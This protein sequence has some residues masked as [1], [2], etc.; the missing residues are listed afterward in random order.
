MQNRLRLHVVF[1]QFNGLRLLKALSSIVID[2]PHFCWL[3][4]G[5]SEG[6][7]E[8]T[9]HWIL[10]AVDT[11]LQRENAPTSRV[12]RSPHPSV[13]GCNRRS[14]WWRAGEPQRLM[15]G[16]RRPW[17][18]RTGYCARWSCPGPTW[19]ENESGGV[20]TCSDSSAT[21][22]YFESRCC[23]QR[24]DVRVTQFRIAARNKS[25]VCDSWRSFQIFEKY[26]NI[27]GRIRNV[28]NA[29]PH[30]RHPPL[31]VK[32]FCYDGELI[33]NAKPPLGGSR[34]RGGNRARMSRGRTD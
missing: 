33:V 24:A 18:G 27:S 17:P 19:P 1:N 32:T 26:Q 34:S 13:P 14:R 31:L 28:G 23:S 7:P 29:S 15:C 16:R 6:E 11:Q 20:V 4:R 9:N 12:P 21:T 25:V 30:T 8:T 5:A 2:W 22:D 10:D 3:L